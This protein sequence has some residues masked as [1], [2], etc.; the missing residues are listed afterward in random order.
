MVFQRN[1]RAADW[2]SAWLGNRMLRQASD[3]CVLE[4][5]VHCFRAL[6]SERDVS[7]VDAAAIDF[8]K[9]AVFWNKDGSFGGYCRVGDMY[10]RLL[11]I[12]KDVRTAGELRP[13]SPNDCRCIFRV[14]VHPP[15]LHP[16]WGELPLQT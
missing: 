12:S 4:L 14:R 9:R 7:V 2:W 11:R 3:D 10:Q 16:G 13:V 6:L 1:D 5:M 15:E 8:T